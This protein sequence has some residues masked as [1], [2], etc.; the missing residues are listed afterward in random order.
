MNGI[1]N[2]VL[3]A[4]ANLLAALVPARLLASRAI[5]DIWERRGYHITPIHFYEPIPDASKLPE[6]AWASYEFHVPERRQ[7]ELVERAKTYDIAGLEGRH[8]F[9]FANGYFTSAD[10]AGLYT[11]IREYQP[12]KILEIGSG[13]STRVALAALEDSGQGELITV[14]PYEAERMPNEPTHRTPVQQLP[15]EVFDEL[16]AND[17]LFID[18]S[19]VAAIGSD[20][21]HLI[22]RVLPRLRPGVLVHFHDIFLP[23][24]YPRSW[25]LEL[26]R[27]WSEQY[28]VH[29]FL[30]FNDEFEVLWAS[31]YLAT[32]RPDLVAWPRPQDA[33]TAPGSLWLRRRTN[34]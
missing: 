7:I 5:F 2:R 11:V 28:L 29:A 14:E 23:D 6:S 10:A 9:T 34:G 25:A 18:S 15:L 31:C 26:R 20:V 8:G 1:R 12:R 17:I 30:L 22:L 27:F 4:G 3:R 33:E 19:H 21:T 16:E 32:R 13:I 24:E